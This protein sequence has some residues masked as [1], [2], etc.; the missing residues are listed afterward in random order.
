MGEESRGRELSH[1]ESRQFDLHQFTQAFQADVKQEADVGNRQAG[2]LGDL[3]IA[4]FVLKFQP[5]DVLLAVGQAVE[6]L[7]QPGHRILLFG[8]GARRVVSGC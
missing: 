2:D 7:K 8:R 4:E 6:L 5:N 3:A 1:R